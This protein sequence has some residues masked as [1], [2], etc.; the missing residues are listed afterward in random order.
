MT[1]RN[2]RLPTD[3]RREAAL[4]DRAATVFASVFGITIGLLLFGSV[5][6]ASEFF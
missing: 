4:R 5:F 1:Q 6:V 2:F 3:D